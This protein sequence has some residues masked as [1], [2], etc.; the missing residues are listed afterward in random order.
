MNGAQ[1]GLRRSLGFWS[2]V[3]TGIV[4]VQPT[5]PMQPFG[6]FVEKSH[7]QVLLPLFLAMLAM[8][9]TA[10]SYGRMAQLHPEAGSAFT[11]VSRELHPLLGFGAGW[12]LLLDYMLNPLLNVVWCAQA[13]ASLLPGIPRLAW[14]FLFTGLFTAANLT[15]IR[16]TARLNTILIIGMTAVI[17]VCVVYMIAFAFH[18]PHRDAARFLTPLFDAHSLS[19]SGVRTGTSL[20]VLTYLGFDGLSTLSEETRDPE[21]TVMR[22]MLLTCLVTGVLSAVEVYAAQL[23]MPGVTKFVNT[24]TAYIQITRIAA[25]AFWAWVLSVTLIVASFGSGAGA[26]LSGARLLYGMGRSNALPKSLFGWVTEH[27]RIPAGNVLLIGVITLLCSLVISYETAAELLN[28]GALIA[29]M[30]V[31][32]CAFVHSARRAGR[33]DPIS[34]LIA[35]CGFAFS[36]AIWISLSRRTLLIGCLWLTCGLLFMLLRGKELSN[37]FAE[38][39]G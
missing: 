9:F 2:L 31:N 39:P 28:F 24:E 3:F 25:G 1:S 34:L 15:R 8:L 30:F 35:V 37:V 18:A 7:G 21:R 27:S 33:R 22:A 4:M 16:T 6:V 36:A 29:F 20:A 38:V 17:A 32:L 19:W 5:A 14:M 11:Y 23:V 12:S 10:V 26:Q 13:A